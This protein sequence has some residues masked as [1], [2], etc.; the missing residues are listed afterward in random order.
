MAAESNE[1]N[2][3]VPLQRITHRNEKLKRKQPLRAPSLQPPRGWSGARGENRRSQKTGVSLLS[4]S[5][6]HGT[7]NQPMASM[8]SAKSSSKKTNRCTKM[9]S[10]SRLTRG[11]DRLRHPF[12]AHML[13]VFYRLRQILVCT[14]FT[15]YP[16]GG[17][18]CT[19]FGSKTACRR[20][21]IRTPIPINLLE[22]AKEQMAPKAALRHLDWLALPKLPF[23]SAKV[24]S[25]WLRPILQYCRSAGSGEVR[26][27]LDKDPCISSVQSGHIR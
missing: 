12:F 4:G 10:Q 27:Q 23:G 9:R 24:R 6:R 25:L 3:A 14:H 20:T 2:H 17:T 22:S 8:R 15:V 18:I 19:I 5:H 13:F 26:S 1:I 16:R 21:R 7:T 11:L